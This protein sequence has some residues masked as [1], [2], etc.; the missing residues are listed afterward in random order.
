MRPWGDIKLSAQRARLLRLLDA[1]FVQLYSEGLENEAMH[2]FRT[3]LVRVLRARENAVYETQLSR[4][5]FLIDQ[6]AAGEPVELELAE[7]ANELLPYERQRWPWL[8]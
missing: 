1:R 7:L 3:D 5:E 6:E 8:G 4:V 2:W